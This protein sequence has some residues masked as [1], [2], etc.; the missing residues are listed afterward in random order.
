M[1]LDISLFF[2]IY[3]RIKN[4]LYVTKNYDYNGNGT[5]SKL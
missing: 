5:F 3:G 2:Y 1:F 4:T